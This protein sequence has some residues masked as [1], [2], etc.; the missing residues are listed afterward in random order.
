MDDEEFLNIFFIDVY[1]AMQR[2]KRHDRISI[3][4][5]FR[6]EGETILD[7]QPEINF[8]V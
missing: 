7:I 3:I 2:Q 8:K 1:K 6:S 5:F 4:V